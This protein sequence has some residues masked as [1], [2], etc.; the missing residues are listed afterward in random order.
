MISIERR[1][2]GLLRERRLIYAEPRHLAL[3]ER[4]PARNEVISLVGC[5]QP[6]EAGANCVVARRQFT[7]CVDLRQPAER[8]FKSFN[9]TTRTA[10]RQAQRMGKVIEVSVNGER[11]KDDFLELVN[12]LRRSK[13]ISRAGRL[14]RTLE[15]YRPVADVWVLY[16]NDYAMCGHVILRDAEAGKA[17]LAYSASRRFEGAEGHRLCGVLNRYLHWREMEYY[18]AAELA[19][20]DLGGIDE[21]Y[22]APGSTTSH[23]KLSFGGSVQ[24][25]YSYFIAGAKWLGSLGVVLWERTTGHRLP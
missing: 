4:R 22:Q 1:L 13:G 19:S 24:E 9:A 16:R 17:R 15:H 11:A 3:Q 23:F 2:F 21:N 8:V 12:N 6:I 5:L 18:Q 7:T 14:S 25:E 20:Y 10:V